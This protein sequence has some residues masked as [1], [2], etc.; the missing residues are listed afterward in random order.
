M[1][2]QTQP[3]P[4][5]T[6]KV[7]PVVHVPEWTDD[8]LTALARLSPAAIT[9]AIVDARRLPEPLRSLLAAKTELEETDEP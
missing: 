6:D 7:K 1:T 8:A 9:D 5:S 3:D 4:E 2:D